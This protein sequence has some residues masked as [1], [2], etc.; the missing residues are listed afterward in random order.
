VINQDSAVRLDK[1]VQHP[2]PYFHCPLHVC[3]L[4]HPGPA[5]S[6]IYPKVSSKVSLHSLERS[7][8]RV[9]AVAGIACPA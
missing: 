8:C 6:I 1:V 5:P 3:T 9:A 4:G 7:D 2:L